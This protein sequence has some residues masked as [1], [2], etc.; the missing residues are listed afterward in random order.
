[1]K[2]RTVCYV[3]DDE[4]EIDRFRR[5]L[6][7]YYVIGAGTSLDAALDELN[8]NGIAKPDVILLDLYFGPLPDEKKREEMT[9]ADV[10]LAAR[11]RKVRQLCLD[12][13]LTPEE[14]FKLAD[15][16]KKRFRRVP[17][18]FFSRRAFLEDAM[19][20]REQGME[21]LEKPDPGEGENYEIAYELHREA[22]KRKID[23]I[24]SLNTF[25]A[26]YGQRIVSFLLGLVPFVLKVGY[27]WFP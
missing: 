16:S 7:K 25:W 18:V 8:R 2:K 11:E 22:I 26:R 14:G 20:V 12:A 13:G 24:I 4:V 9:K 10:E 17:R 19:R 23:R 1:M 15:E 5:N 6:G 21:L 27:D 3:D